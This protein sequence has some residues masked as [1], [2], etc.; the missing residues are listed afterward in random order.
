MTSSS[1][2]TSFNHEAGLRGRG[3]RGAGGS[4]PLEGE[5]GF[6]VF[7]LHLF[8]ADEHVDETSEIFG[9]SRLG[10]ELEDRLAGGCRVFELLVDTNRREDAAGVIGVERVHYL[11]GDVGALIDERGNDAGKARHIKLVVLAKRAYRV[12]NRRA[13]RER[14]SVHVDRNEKL[15]SVEQ[16]VLVH[17]VHGGRAVEQ[18]EVVLV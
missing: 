5:S 7:M 17:E 10:R 12:E 18:D 13:S 1:G 11:G 2:L 14:E 4:S 8:G 15:V 3:R 6:V 9:R 16:R